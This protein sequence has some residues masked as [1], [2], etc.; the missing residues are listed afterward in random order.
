MLMDLKTLFYKDVDSPK[1]NF[2][3]Q[4]SHRQIPS[5][6]FCGNLSGNSK[7]YMEMQEPKNQEEEIVGRFTISD[8]KT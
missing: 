4:C 6:V 1:I 3:I 8:T 7:L 5:K 2:L